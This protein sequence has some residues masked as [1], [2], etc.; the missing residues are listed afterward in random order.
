MCLTTFQAIDLNKKGKDNK[1][2]MYRRLVHS[3]VDVPT[4]QEVKPPSLRPGLTCSSQVAR[5]HSGAHLSGTMASGHGQH[6][7]GSYACSGACV[8]APNKRPGFNQPVDLA[9]C[10]LKRM[11]GRGQCNVPSC[12][13]G[14][15]SGE[16]VNC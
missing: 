1:H 4:I 6:T 15:E 13:I 2:P 11:C 8:A 9:T 3:A 16:T 14:V 10:W 12:S 5:C 7:Q